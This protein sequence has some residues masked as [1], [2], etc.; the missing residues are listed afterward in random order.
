M[1]KEQLKENFKGNYA[2][3]EVIDYIDLIDSNYSYKFNNIKC[4]V[5]YSKIKTKINKNKI[6]KIIK[7]GYI[8]SNKS[9]EYIIHLI[10]SPAKKLIEFNK[11]LTAKNI[12]SG[13]TFI[14]RNEIFIFREEE[15]P[16]VILHE[17][18]HHDKLIHNDDFKI[19]NKEKLMNHFG[20]T[21][22]T[23]LILNEAIIEFWATLIQIAFVSCEYKLNY[24]ELFKL[25]L[26]Y[27]LLKTYQILKL[28]E[29]Y[30][31]KLWCDKCN[32]YSYI[33]FKTILLLN[34]N[35]FIKIYTYPY[36]DTI[37]TNF[38]IIHSAFLNDLL[39]KQINNPSIS[40][41]NQNIQRPLDS[42]CFMLL[43]DL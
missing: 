26:K 1:N 32:I 28:K 40:I 9:K 30:E 35:D 3:K 41:N 7:R 15:Y 36:N 16:K 38:L 12:N 13:F 42:L 27:S 37:I 29:T 21:K 43:S 14:N 4:F 22:D 18:I 23:I 19:E 33:I 24:L 39:K 31:N 6:K 5:Y 20:I 25:E 11:I 17:L 8:I 34:I 10:L 2:I